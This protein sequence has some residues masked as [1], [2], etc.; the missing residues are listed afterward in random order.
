M[1]ILQLIQDRTVLKGNSYKS[2]YK[3]PCLLPISSAILFL[4]NQHITYFLV[5]WT[6]NFIEDPDNIN[7]KFGT[8]SLRPAGF[9]RIRFVGGLV[10]LHILGL[11]IEEA[12]CAFTYQ[13]SKHN[14]WFQNNL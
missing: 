11:Q 9:I 2:L 8:S 6:P 5:G 10:E 4:P 13:Y 12:T 7:E 14:Y 3:P 1:L